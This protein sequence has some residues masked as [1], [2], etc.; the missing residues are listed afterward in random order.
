MF[1]RLV[2]GVSS[3]HAAADDGAPREFSPSRSDVW[4][5][6]TSGGW[7]AALCSASRASAAR[8]VALPRRSRGSSRP[9]ALRRRPIGTAGT[10]PSDVEKFPLPWVALPWVL[11]V[12]V[13]PVRSAGAWL[14]PPS[15]DASNH[16]DDDGLAAIL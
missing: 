9:L 7:R 16:D 2:D 15:R 11:R 12:P 6:T 14:P 5:T 10:A 4:R 8:P 3:S 1:V 13:P